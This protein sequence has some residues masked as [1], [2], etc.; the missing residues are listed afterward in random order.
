NSAQ[1]RN[2]FRLVLDDFVPSSRTITRTI[3]DSC[4]RLQKSAPTHCSRYGHAATLSQQGLDVSELFIDLRGLDSFRAGVEK[5][6]RSSA[7]LLGI[8]DISMAC[9]V[10]SGS[11]RDSAESDSEVQLGGN[12]LKL[13]CVVPLPQLRL[14]TLEIHDRTPA[15]C[16][17][18][19]LPNQGN[20]VNT[21]LQS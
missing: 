4:R 1:K 14:Y 20:R 2:W 9:G 17:C 21:P 6:G 19:R 10:V 11:R 8:G 3:P 5:F 12:Q 16:S 13:D 18:I 15:L 7:G